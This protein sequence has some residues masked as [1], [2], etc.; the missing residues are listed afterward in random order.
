VLERRGH[1]GVAVLPGGPDEWA[2]ATGAAL[3][4]PS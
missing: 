2:K 4:L 1:R 3:E